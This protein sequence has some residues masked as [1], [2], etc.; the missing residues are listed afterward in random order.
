MIIIVII[1]IYIYVYGRGIESLGAPGAVLR[2][3]RAAGRKGAKGHRV[4]EAKRRQ[5]HHY[6]Y[7]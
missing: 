6:H 1:I 3:G 2:V 7:Y 5:C 4:A